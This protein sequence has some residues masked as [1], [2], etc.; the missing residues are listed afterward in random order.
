ML[1]VIIVIIAIKRCR[2]GRGLHADPVSR[3]LAIVSSTGVR[4]VNLKKEG[5][6]EQF[7]RKSLINTGPSINLEEDVD[8]LLYLTNFLVLLASILWNMKWRFV[9]I[10]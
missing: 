8:E 6:G 10:F 7:R 9:A 4:R 1:A 3:N 5:E 2:D